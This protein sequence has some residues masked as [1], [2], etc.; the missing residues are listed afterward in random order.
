MVRSEDR[1]GSRVYQAAIYVRG[2]TLVSM[3]AIGSPACDDHRLCGSSGFIALR[4]GGGPTQLCNLALTLFP[5][6][7]FHRAVDVC[8]NDSAIRIDGVESAGLY[9]AFDNTFVDCPEIDPFAEI[10]E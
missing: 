6:A 7:P 10:E 8:I 9:E 5:L 2:R 1:Q 3:M 4:S